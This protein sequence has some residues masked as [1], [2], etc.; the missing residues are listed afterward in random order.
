[1]MSSISQAQK[2]IRSEGQ[3]LN[4]KRDKHGRRADVALLPKALS[5]TF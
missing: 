1:M 2:L 3:K 4:V 5:V